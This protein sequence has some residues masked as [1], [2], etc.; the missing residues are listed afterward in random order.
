MTDLTLKLT[1]DNLAKL[2]AY[3]ILSKQDVK[4]IE[5]KLSDIVSETLGDL[6][7]NGIAES[8]VA[9]DGGKT[10]QA[11]TPQQPEDPPVTTD[12]STG[13]E[14][15]DDD[16]PDEVKELSEEDVPDELFKLEIK[17][18]DAGNNAD[19]YVDAVIAQDRKPGRSATKKSFD[20]RNPKVSVEAYTGDESADPAMY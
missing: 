7:S 20:P 13:N 6:L 4:D 17:A 14:L 10:P 12:E 5:Q 9:M 3:I 19:A 18:K 15:S 1:D 8:L 11:L 16:A 2:K